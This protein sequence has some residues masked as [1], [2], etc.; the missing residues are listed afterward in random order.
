MLTERPK[1]IVVTV[2][3]RKENRSKSISVYN[4]T[5]DEVYK[6]IEKCLK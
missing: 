1:S 6:K 2:R 5:L 3:D 4:T